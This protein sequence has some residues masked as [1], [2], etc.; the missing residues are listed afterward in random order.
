M[1]GG[2]GPTGSPPLP[3][4]WLRTAGLPVLELPQATSVVRIHR[5]EHDPVFFSP[6]SG[7][8]PI[9]RFDS[10]SGAFGVLY[11]AQSLEGAF[12]E[13][14]LRNPQRRLVDSSEIMARA[15]SVLRLSRAIRLVRLFGAGLQ[16]VGT[17]NAVS[18]GPYGPSG[19]WADALY[20]HPDH[21][22]GIAYT[23]RHDPEQLCIAL[24]SR[25]DIQLELFSGPT[26]LSDVLADVASILRRYGKGIA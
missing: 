23:S 24:F 7:N 3:S 6:G 2:R 9:G 4:S 25:S 20:S 18:T 22:D 17:D 19:A 13:T 5:A 11:I 14:I 10:P 15:V 16:A 21:P 1:S 26:P 8:A 12:A